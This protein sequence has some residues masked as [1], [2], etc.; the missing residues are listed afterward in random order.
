MAT[1]RR[2]ATPGE[3]KALAHPLRMRILRL[4][5]HDSLTNKELADRL[6]QNPA[7]V[8][9]H[10]RLLVANGFLR[11]EKPRTGARGATEKPYRATRKSWTLSADRFPADQRLRRDLAMVDAFRAELVEA[12]PGALV[13]GARLGLRLSDEGREE[14]QRRLAELIEEFADRPDDPEGERYGLF[15][16]VHRRA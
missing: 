11:A 2:E 14:L 5:L 16:S 12:G 13:E 6:D 4:C 9:H 3:F 10:V 1:R 15:V 7:T 8:L